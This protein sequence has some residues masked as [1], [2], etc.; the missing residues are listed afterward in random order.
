MAG[1]AT[2]WSGSHPHT[3]T[4]EELLRLWR[5]S[6]PIL[7]LRIRRVRLVQSWARRPLHHL[8]VLCALFG[9][10]PNEQMGPLDDPG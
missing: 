5:L 6:I 10:L 8:Q 2:D 1:K 4:N 7:E 9:E 3:L